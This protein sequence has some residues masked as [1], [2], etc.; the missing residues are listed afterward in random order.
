MKNILVIPAF[1]PSVNLINLIDKLL[2]S[3]V[4]IIIIDDGSIS[5]ESKDIFN[6][7]E[8]LS[9][10]LIL[11]HKVKLGKGKALKTGYEYCVN[12]IE[13]DYLITA[14]ADGQHL[15]S[16]IIRVS[17]NTLIQKSDLIMGE[18]EFDAKVPFR[19]RV[20]NVITAKIFSF[21]YAL[22]LKDTQTGLRAYKKDIIKELI[23]IK[24][25][26]YEYESNVLKWVAKSKKKISSIKIS[27][28]YIDDNS[29]S[30]FS[31]IKDSIKI[32]ISIIGF[33][34]SS[35]VSF[36]LD[37]LIFIILYISTNALFISI[38]FARIASGFVNFRINKFFF[39]DNQEKPFWYVQ[40]Y[41]IL[42]IA[43]LIISYLLILLLINLNFSP[44]LSKIIADS[45]LYFVSIF[46]YKKIL[47]L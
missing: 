32:Y 14:D 43:V 5:Y 39:L 30:H 41:L 25:N 45:I 28:V 23:L 40:R 1:N 38:F 21:L 19:S 7:L 44:Y 2:N 3:F 16:D 18:R 20:G 11:K 36:L 37:Y 33:P 12:N 8:K 24:G 34:V 42:S 13:F 46:F 47:S 15:D 22:N 4:K 17:N 27:T 10:I 9:K 31:P 35:F 29:S 6:K 26:G